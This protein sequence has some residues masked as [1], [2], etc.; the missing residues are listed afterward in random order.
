MPVLRTLFP[1]H[2]QGNLYGLEKFWAFLKYRTDKRPVQF[3][4]ELR[5]ILVNFQTLDDFHAA[6]MVSI[7]FSSSNIITPLMFS[8]PTTPLRLRKFPLRP[9]QLPP[10]LP[11]LP[12][13][14]V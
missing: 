13:S 12:R 4:D 6:G 9:L 11:P 7:M 14:L 2:V 5:D 3:S 10:P 1:S 8:G